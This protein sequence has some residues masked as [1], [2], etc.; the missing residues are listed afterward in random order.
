MSLRSGHS[1][2]AAF[3]PDFRN[4]TLMRSQKLLR[5]AWQYISIT[6]TRFSSIA[7]SSMLIRTSS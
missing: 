2:A 1:G 7:T 4:L 5:I 6:E 3:E